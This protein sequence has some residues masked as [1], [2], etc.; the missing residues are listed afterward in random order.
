[1]MAKKTIRFGTDGIRG[2]V[3]GDV[4]NPQ[5]VMQLGWAIGRVM[6]Q[7]GET[8]VVGKDTR[9]SGYM[10]ESALESGLAAAGLH[11]HLL[12]P[13]STPGIA[14]MTQTL[15]AC[16]GIVISASHNSYEDNG[17][18]IFSK[19]GGKITPQQEDAIEAMLQQPMS[20]VAASEIGRASRVSDAEG[21]YLEFC[22]Q[23]LP[24]DFQCHG[25]RVVIDCA[26]GANYKVAPQLFR[27]LGAEVFVLSAD[28]NGLN[29]NESCGSTKPQTLQQQVLAHGADCGIAYDGDGDRLIMVDEHGAV[30]DGDEILY[31][32]VSAAISRGEKVTGV[33]GTHMTNE[34]VVRSLALKGVDCK[35][36]DVGDK[37]VLTELQS[38]GWV[39][40]GEP[41]GHI[42]DLSKATTGDG[43]VASLGV[44]RALIESQCTLAELRSECHKMPQVIKSIP[45]PQALS[46]EALDA[47]INDQMRAAKKKL[48]QGRVLIRKSGT[49]PVIRL[50]VEGESSEKIHAVVEALHHA[51]VA[52]FAPIS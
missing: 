50:M 26:N 2:Y 29:I 37:Y 30:V 19:D 32:L 31:V 25:M 14:F 9:L 46:G 51:F 4:I 3:G 44:V 11:V 33:V 28:P 35:R 10:L 47:L 24:R 1:M 18:K 22:K 52:D 8:V 21:R 39:Y 17:I 6:G 5:F 23:S 48:K 7:V 38:H 45:L 16:A 42:I 43:I 12:G 36:V 13:L 15:R 49:E 20:C 34:G 27:E 40:G 41:S